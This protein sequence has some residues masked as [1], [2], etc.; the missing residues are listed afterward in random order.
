MISIVNGDAYEMLKTLPDKSID[1]VIIDPPYEYTT[2][3]GAGCFGVKHRNYHNEYYKVSANIEDI[4][5]KY[6]DKGFDNKKASVWAYKELSRTDISHISSGFDFSLL[7]VLDNKMK[8]INI[9]IYM[10]Q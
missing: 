7:D 2:G 9:Y 6:I 3:E 4:K 10:V 8:K 5:Q 1:L